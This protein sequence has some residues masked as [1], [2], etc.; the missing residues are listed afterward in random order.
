MESSIKTAIVTGAS[1]GIGAAIATYLAATGFAVVVNYRASG[2]EAEAVCAA[3]AAAGGIAAACQADITTEAAAAELVGFALTTFGR[4]DVLV[5]NAG[6]AIP[7][8]LAE[9][10]AEHIAAHL[11]VNLAGLLYVSKHAA[12]AFGDRGGS[13]VNISSINGISPVPGG[14]V[15]SATKAAVNAITVSLARELGSKNIRVNAV[16]PGLTMTERYQREV[17]DDA[18]KYVIETT[19][20]GR[21]GTPDDLAGTV[22]FLAS[23]ASVWVTGQVIAVSGGAA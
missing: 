16:A 12:F 11:S 23:D 21:L 2:P 8:S 10:D 13:I 4:L 19:P 6:I 9:I 5:N 22:G 1:S 7:R 3:I 14:A 15:Y 18:K 17:P 20:L